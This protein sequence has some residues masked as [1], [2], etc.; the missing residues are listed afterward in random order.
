MPGTRGGVR[1]LPGVKICGLQRGRSGLVR[2]L[3]GLFFAALQA[4]A[5]PFTHARLLTQKRGRDQTV[6]SMQF[7]ILGKQ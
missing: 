1:F 2:G 4:I 5:H 3:F 6:R 7:V